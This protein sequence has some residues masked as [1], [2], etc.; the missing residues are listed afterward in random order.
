MGSAGSGKSYFI[1][2]KIILRCLKEKIRVLVCR[3][4]GT[5]LRQTVFALF[6]DVLAQWHLSQ[7]VKINESDFRLKFPNGSEVLF[8]GLDEE[9]K[10]LSLTDISCIWIEEAYEVQYNMIEQLNLRMRGKQENQQL[11][12]SWNPISKSSYLY[13]LSVV[14]PPESSIFIHSTYKDNPFL[15]EDYIRALEELKTRNPQKWQIYGLGNWGI[16]NEGLVYRNW[17]VREFDPLLLASSGLE[18]R[19]GCDF[20]YIDPSV[21]VASLFDKQN[22]IIYVYDEFYKSGIQLDA[23]YQ[24]IVDMKL[25]KSKIYCDSAE[26]RSI[27][28]L[29]RNGVNATP[30]IKGPDS[31]N[32]RITFLQNHQIIISPKCVNVIREFSNYAYERDKRTGQMTDK[33]IHDFSHCSDALGYAYSDIYT[34]SGFRTLDKNILG[35]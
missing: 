1:T 22:K 7:F 26:P 5:T 18:P 3:K 16:D 28:F 35:L 14:N 11:M 12:L 33:T 32:S 27:D 2:Q 15:K 9:T 8:T 24:A 30:C 4:Y 34:K 25:Q 13:E 10:L 21:V 29:K 23:L 17:E 20:G 31:V 6:K 19:N